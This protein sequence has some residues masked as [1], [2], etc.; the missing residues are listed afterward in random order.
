M[1]FLSI[2]IAA[3]ALQ[4]PSQNDGQSTTATLGSNLAT[5]RFACRHLNQHDAWIWGLSTAE[6]RIPAS[7]IRESVAN[8]RESMPAAVMTINYHEV[9]R[10]FFQHLLTTRQ[11]H[12]G[13]NIDWAACVFLTPPQAEAL[14]ASQRPGTRAQPGLRVQS[15]SPPND[16]MERL[17]AQLGSTANPS[18][19]QQVQPQQPAGSIIVAPRET[20]EQR[21]RREADE[22]RQ[23]EVARIDAAARAQ[24]RVRE[25]REA[26]EQRRMAA[27]FQ[28]FQ[29]RWRARQAACVANPRSCPSRPARVSAQ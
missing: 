6:Y 22:R 1:E 9:N 5:V 19:S 29:A 4:L 14:E 12:H 25:Q 11:V 7:Q 8:E 28:S 26:A 2:A 18:P 20:L 27:D 3:L 17:L 15:W 24:R 10:L 13:F 21:A 23:A 16:A